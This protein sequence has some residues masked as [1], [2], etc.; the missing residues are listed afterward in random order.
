MPQWANHADEARVTPSGIALTATAAD[1]LG[2]VHKQVGP[3]VDE[4]WNRLNRAISNRPMITQSARFLPKLFNAVAPSYVRDHNADR[5]A[6]TPAL[7]GRGPLG[8]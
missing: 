3:R 1:C 7:T 4:L 5:A 8:V 2:V 6:D